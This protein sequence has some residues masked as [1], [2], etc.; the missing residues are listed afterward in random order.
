[1]CL[2]DTTCGENDKQDDENHE[3]EGRGLCDG[4]GTSYFAYS[5]LELLVPQ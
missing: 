3:D 1:M 4:S 2:D 5:T